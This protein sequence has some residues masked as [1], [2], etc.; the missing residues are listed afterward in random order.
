[1]KICEKCGNTYYRRNRL[2]MWTGRNPGH[3]TGWFKTEIKVCNPCMPAMEAQRIGVRAGLRFTK[4][5]KILRV[6]RRKKN[7]VRRIAS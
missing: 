4:T 2:E 7:E 6:G 3:R 1:M 5:G